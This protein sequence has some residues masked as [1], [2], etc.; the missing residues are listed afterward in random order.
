VTHYYW[1]GPVPE[2]VALAEQ[3]RPEIDRNGT[4]H[5]RVQFYFAL[6]LTAIRRDR[7]VV[8]DE[9]LGMFDAQLAAAEE[10][11]NPIDLADGVFGLGFAHLWR[12]ELHEAEERLLAT[13]KL[14]ER[15]PIGR[16]GNLRALALTYL[17]V[18]QRKRGDVAGARRYARQ[19]LDAA[20]AA[21]MLPYI[22]M[23]RANL[24]WA[25]WRDGDHAEAERECRE[26]LDLWDKSQVGYPVQ[27]ASR[28]PMIA[29]ACA[30]D[31][32]DEAIACARPLLMPGQQALP[33]AQAAALEQAIRAWDAGQRSVANGSLEQAM[34]LAREGGYL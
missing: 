32:I 2:M 30:A 8:S 31:R 6:M 25:A 14:A 4:P 12:G 23:A 29:L 7:Y 18:L 33:A 17:T 5:E 21:Q 9:T 27:W 13:L 19:A 3:I 15:T 28:W 10:T 11:R 16:M 20:T 24:A 34:A 1:L 22:A 26:A